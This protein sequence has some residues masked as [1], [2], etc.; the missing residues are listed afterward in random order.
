[1][2]FIQQQQKYN[3]FTG[4]DISIIYVPQKDGVYGILFR[5]YLCLLH[6]TR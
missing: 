6:S 4:V 5:N 3:V 2:H 1:M